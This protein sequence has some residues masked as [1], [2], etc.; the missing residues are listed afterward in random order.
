MAS[1]T[2]ETNG[3]TKEI[4]YGYMYDDPKP[5]EI[6][7]PKPKPL[8]DA[9][10]RALALH[11]INDIGD[12]DEKHLAPAK[13]AAFYKL[14]GHDYDRLFVNMPPQSISFIYQVQGCQHML[15]PTEDDF[16]AP[17]IPA[18]T[19]KGFARWQA[20]Q[21]L[22]EPQVH[23]PII[24]F[25][26]KNWALKHPEY[27]SVFPDDLPATVFP[28]D[29]DQDT[30]RWHQSCA[31]KLRAE[32]TTREEAKEEREAPS[33]DPKA[34]AF[35]DEKVPFSHVRPKPS[36][37]QDYD[38]FNTRSGPVPVSYVRP[39]EPR[40]DRYDPRRSPE[41]PREPERERGHDLD[42]DPLDI[43]RG[44]YAPPRKVFPPEEERTSRR[45]SFTDYPHMIPQETQSMQIPL[46]TDRI[47]V[48]R[49]HSQPR[50]YT[51]PSSSDAEVEPATSRSGR[52]HH[53]RSSR[54]SREPPPVT[55][56]RI[57]NSEGVPSSRAA[58]MGG[59]SISPRSHGYSSR[60]EPPITVVPATASSLRADDSKKKSIGSGIKDKISNLFPGVSIVGDDRRSRSRS[61]KDDR[62]TGPDRAARELYRDSRRKSYSDDESDLSE[63]EDEV[64]RRRRAKRLSKESRILEQRDIDRE[65]E[66]DIRMKSRDRDRE[67]DRDRDR[68]H[69]RDRVRDRST[70]DRDRDRYR[71]LDRD[72]DEPTSR[73]ERSRGISTGTLRRDRE[74]RE[75]HDDDDDLDLSPHSSRSGRAPRKASGPG[76]SP[77]LTQADLERRTGS[78]ADMDRRDWTGGAGGSM[79]SGRESD[80]YRDSRERDRDPRDRE[81]RWG[82]RDDLRSR[83]RPMHR[84]RLSS[85]PY[86]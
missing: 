3:Q 83:E 54:D 25:A 6:P 62:A 65:R 9:L 22:L 7:I 12:K 84:E 16:A 75:R 53:S 4:F 14:A 38:Y 2:P 23:V 82:S 73:R 42:P 19:V 32:A 63:S 47:S 60:R 74:H 10:L 46:R 34:D 21:I 79:L 29:T 8:L 15:L 11:I 51:S 85:P 80:R 69:E 71:D 27:G 49:R 26:V 17:S 52:R 20:I 55:S 66:R 5:D 28:A 31:T 78:R 76:P 50:H 43:S 72:D 33:V 41:R 57:F 81:G 77:Y 18:L 13:M 86:R 59:R 45:P 67:R 56:H 64:E 40:T 36:V 1:P 37:P 68:D 30:D 61:Q 24:Q 35:P 44:R 48:P 58:P 39:P 70:R